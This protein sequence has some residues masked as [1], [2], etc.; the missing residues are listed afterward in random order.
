MKHAVNIPPFTDAATVVRWAREAEEAG[1][2]GVFLWDHIQWSPGVA[3]LDPWVMLG[4]VATVTERVRL[5]PLITPLSR[6]RPHVVAKQLTT[7]D[8]L[9]GGRAVLGVGLGAPAD[10]DFGDLGEVTDARVRGA[11]LDEAL[12]VVDQLLRGATDFTGEH[13]R[14]TA[15]FRP[16]PVQLPRP[17]IWVA[18]TAPNRRPLRR[19]QRWDGAV[20]IGADGPLSPEE[21]AAHLARLESPV[22]EGW[23]VVVPR[24][25]G[26]P[27]AEYA[28]AG[29]T[30]L[31]ADP[32]PTGEG[33]EARI[34]ELISRGP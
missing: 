31:V 13:Y 29:A 15:D 19:A 1:W 16:R 25:E 5:G 26:V 21:L 23:E 30:W 12:E 24:R 33:W 17:P 32:H 27:A 3:P 4:A 7:L 28:S 22:P 14:V 18:G 9:S 6:R 34:T 8:H 20:P 10:R 2:D 11:M